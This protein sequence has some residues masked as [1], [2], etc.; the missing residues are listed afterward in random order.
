MVPELLKERWV[1]RIDVPF[2]LR[3]QVVR[4]Y[5]VQNFGSS[6]VTLTSA[7]FSTTINI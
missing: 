6:E 5:A 4:K 2:T 7:E 3:R 1:N